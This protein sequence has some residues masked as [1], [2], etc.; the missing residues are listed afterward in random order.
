MVSNK[1][2]SHSR[3]SNE[4]KTEQTVISCI[5]CS[6]RER[7]VEVLER[8]LAEQRLQIK[9]LH[10]KLLSMAPQAMEYWQRLEMSR[11]ARGRNSGIVEHGQYVQDDLGVGSELNHI[12]GG[13]NNGHNE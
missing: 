8:Q 5:G 2:A 7:L 1:R 13:L 12:F 11:E 6:A 9:E 3:V 10:E 4:T